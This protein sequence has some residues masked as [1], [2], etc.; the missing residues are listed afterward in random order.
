MCTNLYN[1][2]L[3]NLECG[4]H[5][6]LQELFFQFVVFVLRFEKTYRP[7]VGAA[8]RGQLMREIKAWLDTF[9]DKENV[10][11]V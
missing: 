7:M 2:K 1:N 8:P 5:S 4:L 3:R 10:C 9:K 6:P 11:E